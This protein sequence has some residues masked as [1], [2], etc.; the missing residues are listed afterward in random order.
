MEARKA[1]ILE[2]AG[3]SPA[4]AIMLV[5]C[6]IRELAIMLIVGAIPA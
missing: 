6:F 3:S 2:V 5:L 1:H 4:P